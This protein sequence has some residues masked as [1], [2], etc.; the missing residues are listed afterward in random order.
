MAKFLKTNYKIFIWPILVLILH[1]LATYFAWYWT[2]PWFD[3]PM[4]FL[5]GAS[6][7]LST[8][9]WL[10][11]YGQPWWLLGLTMISVT[12]LVA[13]GWEIFELLIDIFFNTTTQLGLYDALKDLYTGITG[14]TITAIITFKTR[15]RR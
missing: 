6:I 5:G 8:Y 14:A 13:V 4:H 11:R 10:R 9:F 1:T 2:I 15:N 3:T 12:A 7:A